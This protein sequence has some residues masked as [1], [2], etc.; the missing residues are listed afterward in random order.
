MDS[1]TKVAGS[2]VFKAGVYFQS[3]RYGEQLANPRAERYRFQC[4]RLQSAQYWQSFR[5]RAV[6]RVQLLHAG[7]RE[8]VCLDDLS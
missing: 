1:V 7:E 2:H 6:G 4:Q 5:Q 3:A 8:T